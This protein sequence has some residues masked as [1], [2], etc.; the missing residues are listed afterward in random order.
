MRKERTGKGR[1]RPAPEGEAE[2]WA[3]LVV[4]LGNEVAAARLLLGDT[5]GVEYDGKAV[6]QARR[7]LKMAR[8]I[9]RLLRPA[10][11]QLADILAGQ[12]R[13]AMH[14]LSARRDAQ[15][16]CDTAGSI[17]QRLD[18]SAS[19]RLLT[20]LAGERR[21]RLAP[22]DDVAKARQAVDGLATAIHRINLRQGDPAMVAR[23]A[24]SLYRKARR[25]WQ[26]ARVEAGVEALHEWRKRVRDRLHVA[27]LFAE[28]WP[29]PRPPGRRKLERL[30]D[31]LGKERDLALLDEALPA[32]D[33]A[34]ARIRRLVTK[35]RA[36]LTGKA[37]KLAGRV[38]AQK[39]GKV[40]D[41]WLSHAGDLRTMPVNLPSPPLRPA[42]NQPGCRR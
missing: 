22:G 25:G 26:A 35:R 21:G 31:L 41:H 16:F 13:E 18:T 5:A 17:A 29:E 20:K 30:S 39:P 36:R 4:S 1:K 8:S 11:P 9:I 6:H 10:L 23:S 37:L 19:R 28:S 33:E 3:R 15:V 7:H 42:E 38:F 12:A 2:I 32:R 40:R 34:A 24:A 14:H 27:G